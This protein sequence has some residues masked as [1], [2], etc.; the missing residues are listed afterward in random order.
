MLAFVVALRLLT[1]RRGV[2]S[3]NPN[4]VTVPYVSSHLISSRP[5]IYPL[6]PPS[7][8]SSSNPQT[9]TVSQSLFTS[10]QSMHVSSPTYPR[11]NI[12]V[13]TEFAQ[14]VSS[15]TSKS[16]MV[17]VH[18]ALRNPSLATTLLRARKKAD[19]T[20]AAEL[21]FRA[22]TLCRIQRNEQATRTTP[23][24]GATRRLRSER[25]VHASHTKH[26]STC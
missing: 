17:K 23:L 13:T 18:K 21:R 4:T 25:T 5:L 10:R 20:L 7:R 15:S 11:Q 26:D 8:H 14:H 2:V 16:M 3:E 24:D 9:P 22:R 1:A 6:S 19:R 12:S